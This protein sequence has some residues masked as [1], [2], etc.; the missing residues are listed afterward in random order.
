MRPAANYKT[1]FRGDLIKS[2]QGQ[3]TEHRAAYRRARVQG[4]FS[5][6]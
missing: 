4:N 2:E 3:L 5:A 1:P 6:G